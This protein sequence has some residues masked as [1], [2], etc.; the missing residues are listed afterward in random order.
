[1]S[2]PADVAPVAPSGVVSPDDRRAH[3]GLVSDVIARMSA[4]SQHVKVVTLSVVAVLTGFVSTS[5]W[6]ALV[7]L[8]ALA[9]CAYLD[10]YYLALERAY[11]RLYD[12]VRLGRVEAFAMAAGR[13]SVGDALAALVSPA[14]LAYHGGI[15]LCVVAVSV[16][17]LLA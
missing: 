15:A 2:Q 12:D 1:M 10:G 5:G 14:V 3:L 4:A 6:P 9:P 8:L 13:P 7:V 16:I 11:R 17:Q